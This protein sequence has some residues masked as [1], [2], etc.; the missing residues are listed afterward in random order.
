MDSQ[1]STLDISGLSID[2]VASLAKGCQN[3]AGIMLVVD[4]TARRA[5]L[6]R[7]A[8]TNVLPSPFFSRHRNVQESLDEHSERTI[9]N[10]Q[11][12]SSD[13]VSCDT[14]LFMTP[15]WSRDFAHGSDLMIAPCALAARLLN[16]GESIA[17]IKD[18]K[19][20]KPVTSNIK[21]HAEV[22]PLYRHKESCFD[23][24]L[25][26]SEG[27][28]INFY[29]V[30]NPESPIS[31]SVE[32]NSIADCVIRT[33]G[34]YCHVGKDTTNFAILLPL[35]TPYDEINKSGSML[36]ST[37][38]EILTSA[39]ERAFALRVQNGE[40]SS[41]HTLLRFLGGIRNLEIPSDLRK[42]E[43]PTGRK[44]LRIRFRDDKSIIGKSGLT[45]S[46][47]EFKFP[48]Q[49][50]FSEAVMASSGDRGTAE[51]IAHQIRACLG[52]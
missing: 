48:H 43:D 46:T 44:R 40:V 14:Q 35:N 34:D 12:V 32:R 31:Y 11:A 9:T 49:K 30:L 24:E 15:G 10:V 20:R 26:T 16:P 45:L 3:N 36:T 38:V 2:E 50:G 6:A 17:G 13:A 8:V 39:A 21:L 33:H 19:W 41:D 7:Q 5:E 47:F 52:R 18:V 28:T 22:G 23:G 37:I 1:K 25:V 27:R 4:E 51:K 29:G 42:I